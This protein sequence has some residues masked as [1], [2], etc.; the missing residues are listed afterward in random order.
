[1][2]KTSIMKIRKHGH[3]RKKLKKI[4]FLE[5]GKTAHVHDLAEFIL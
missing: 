1:M 3:G 5:S 2:G 4:S